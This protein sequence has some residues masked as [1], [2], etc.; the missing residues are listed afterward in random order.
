MDFSKI[1]RLVFGIAFIVILYFIIFDALKIMYKDVKS[2][3]KK[4]TKFY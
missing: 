4:K 3:W 2:E 1:I